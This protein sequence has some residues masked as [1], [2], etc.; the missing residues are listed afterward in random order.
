MQWGFWEHSKIVSILI[1]DIVTRN[2][3]VDL[4][5]MILFPRN[6]T[7]WCLSCVTLA[8]DRTGGMTSHLG[9]PNWTAPEVFV[10]ASRLIYFENFYSVQGPCSIKVHT[11]LCYEFSTHIKFAEVGKQIFKKLQ[12][13][14]FLGL[15][16]YCQFTKFCRCASL[17][18]FIINPQ[19]TNQPFSTKYCTPL[20]QNSPK[21]IFVNIFLCMHYMLYL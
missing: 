17:Q 2:Q 12:V 3:F 13:H 6:R 16:L 8:S 18:I 5:F 4:T 11:H 15:F 10:E 1:L 9:T 7:R 19:I 20:W 14:K 21:V